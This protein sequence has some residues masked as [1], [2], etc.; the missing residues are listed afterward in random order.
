MELARFKIAKKLIF[1]NDH[2][3]KFNEYIK[4]IYIWFHYAQVKTF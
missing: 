4:S 1:L 2:K 3:N